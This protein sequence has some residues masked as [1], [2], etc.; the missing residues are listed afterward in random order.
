MLLKSSPLSNGGAIFREEIPIFVAR[1]TVDANTMK[2]NAT[3]LR[4]PIITLIVFDAKET[5][6]LHLVS[7]LDNTCS[8]VDAHRRVNNATCNH[9]PIWET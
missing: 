5:T 7:L 8:Q 1:P 3:N 6:L 4:T 9:R 2:N